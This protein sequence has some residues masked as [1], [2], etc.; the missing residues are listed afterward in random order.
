MN[1]GSID[2]RLA[3]VGIGNEKID[4]YN[5]KD[6]RISLHGV[7][8]DEGEG[9]Y[10][11]VPDEVALK[12]TPNLKPLVRMTAGGRVRFVTNSPFI[13]IKASVPAFEPMPHMS[14]TGSLLPTH[15]QQLGGPNYETHPSG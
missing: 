4:W 7:Y 10:M 8:F 12:A 11:R 15:I 5:A 14:I 2:E 13:A 1:I 3:S 9:L 6:E